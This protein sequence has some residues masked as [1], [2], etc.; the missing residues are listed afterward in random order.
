[1]KY[2]KSTKKETD[3]TVAIRAMLIGT[4]VGVMI[5]AV[6]LILFAFL[7][8]AVK[9]VPQFMIP[10]AAM[11]CAVMGALVSGYISV[12]IYGSKGLIYGGLAGFLLFAIITLISFIISRDKFTYLTVIRFLIM[13]FSGSIGGIWSV[14]KRKHR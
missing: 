14:N 1:M 4:A 10:I 3:V 6:F 13:V 11:F 9:S 12:R 7:F 8:V 2:D 5:S